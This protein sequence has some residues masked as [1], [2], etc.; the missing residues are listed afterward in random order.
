MMLSTYHTE[1]MVSKSRRS[2][3]APG[4]VEE[5][6]KPYVV[7]DYNQHMGDVHTYRVHTY[8]GTCRDT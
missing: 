5:I 8:I 2:R 3:T 4:G 6:E 7:E 1:V